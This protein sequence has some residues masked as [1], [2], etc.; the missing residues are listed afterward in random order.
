MANE[1]QSGMTE[2]LRNVF[3]RLENVVQNNGEFLAQCPCHNDA[4]NSL[5]V[6][7]GN[8]GKILMV[9]HAGCKTKDILSAV[10]LSFSDLFADEKQSNG[11]PKIV[12]Q[13]DY[14]DEAG[15]LLYQSVR[16]E[17]KTFRQRKPDPSGGWIW[18]LNGVRRVLYRLP[19]LLEADSRQT[20]FVVEGEKDVDRLRSLGLVATC[21]VGGAGKWKEDY[22][23][24]LSGRRV[25]IFPDN[26]DAGRKHAEQVSGSLREVAESVRILSLPKLPEKG[27]VSDWLDAGGSKDEL[28]RLAEEAPVWEPAENNDGDTEPA[29][30]VHSP[31]GR[32]ETAN[33]R[34]F[35]QQNGNNVR[36]CHPWKKW[37]G[38]DGKRWMQDDTA[39]MERLAKR[40]ADQIW[41]EAQESDS[42]VSRRFAANSAKKSGISAML[43][44]A[45]SEP[46][47]PILPEHLDTDPWL[48]NVQNGTVDLR[49]GDLCE[50]RREDFITKI[51]PVAFNP[52]A[53]SLEWDR[54]L[55]QIFGDDEL[56]RFVQR[57]FGMC[58][59]GD[60]SAQVLPIFWGGGSNGKS[61]LLNLIM[62]TIGPDFTMQAQSDFLLAKRN[63][64]HPTER[65]DLFGRRLVVCSETGSG[66]KLNESLVKELTGGERIRARKMNQDFWE[67]TATHKLILSTN[68]RP[69][70][71][72]NDH[73]TWR[74]IAL[75][76]FNNQFWDEDKCETGPPE[77]KANKG[78]MEKLRAETEGILAWA[79][80]GCVDW[81]ASGL[82]M[83]DSVK[84]ATD[85]YRSN[86][87]IIGQFIQAHCVNTTGAR[88]K[89]SDLYKRLE[90][91]CDETGE[92]PPSKKALAAYLPTQGFQKDPKIK[93]ESWYLDIEIN[94]E[95]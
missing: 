76:P 34:R 64:S 4:R 17:P 29:I 72:G 36:Y 85:S 35:A 33:G 83:P 45:S 15:I 91:F 41:S 6:G 86:E 54:F 12:E 77:L 14:R 60:V 3:N 8:D 69:V 66:R 55:E 84:G 22:N 58:L 32:T 89:F 79:V 9:C 93:R 57:L 61:T 87:D 44:L 68:H 37:L 25:V 10:G 65:A 48:L 51:C 53:G 92:D 1:F 39:A 23:E 16:M 30:S 70:I 42:D 47:I 62:E 71:K 11:K 46:G 63:D 5:S 24:P 20:V 80:Q 78:L 74:R 81:H 95:M 82:M 31:K 50:H 38:W 52:E 28:L 18:K 43:S 56:M 13:Y 59:T 2:Q 75:V 73:A 7:S 27:D 19:K 40:V 94:I 49:T 26:D 88:T 90:S 21:N 67:F